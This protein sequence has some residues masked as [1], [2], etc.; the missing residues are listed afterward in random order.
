[1]KVVT[2]DEKIPNTDKAYFSRPGSAYVFKTPTLRG[3]KAQ[4]NYQV[5]V[6][7]HV[8]YF[9]IYFNNLNFIIK[10]K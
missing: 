1:M 8:Y 4:H 5:P 7:I 2:G 3:D 10:Y 6:I 9:T